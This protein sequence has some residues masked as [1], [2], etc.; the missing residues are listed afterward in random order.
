MEHI[1]SC[2]KLFDIVYECVRKF[3]Q[4]FNSIYLIIIPGEN[5]FCNF[6]KHSYDL[7]LELVSKIFVNNLISIAL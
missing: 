3:V 6:R 4:Q 5:C 7:G 1:L 2:S